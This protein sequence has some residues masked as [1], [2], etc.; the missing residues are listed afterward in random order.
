MLRKGK[1][2]SLNEAFRK[3]IGDDGPCYVEKYNMTPKEAVDTVKRLGGVPV[4]AHPYSLGDDSLIGEFKKDGLMGLEV[5]HSDHSELMRE[6]YAKIASDL[7]LLVTGGSDC[8]GLGK[9][10]VLMGGVKIPYK[11]VEDLKIASN[12]LSGGI[13]SK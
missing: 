4:L 1:V 7:G 6:R 13:K 3:Y 5:Y 8:H 12:R 10:R 2:S 9:G 11:Y